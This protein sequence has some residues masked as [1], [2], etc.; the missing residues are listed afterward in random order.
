MKPW[1]GTTLAHVVVVVDG[2]EIRISRRHS[3]R[4]VLVG[5][6]FG[7]GSS[8]NEVWRSHHPMELYESDIFYSLYVSYGASELRVLECAFAHS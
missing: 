6:N 1:N 3:V 4:V 2:A 5:R 7:T 8:V